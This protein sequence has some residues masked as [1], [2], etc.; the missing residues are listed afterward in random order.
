MNY[1]VCLY[2]PAHPMG[3]PRLWFWQICSDND[4]EM[5][6]T[7]DDKQ[8]AFDCASTALDAVMMEAKDGR[9]H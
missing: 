7:S 9:L 6:G 3:H 8:D 4:I 5:S 1:L 2:P